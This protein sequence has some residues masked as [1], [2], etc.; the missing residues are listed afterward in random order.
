MQMT[1]TSIDSFQN[2]GI[3]FIGKKEVPEILYKRKL[4][5]FQS[6]YFNQ[7]LTGK[8]T[9]RTEFTVFRAMVKKVSTY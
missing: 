1:D 3:L 9:K 2:L 5:D 6:R 7:S 4:T 8:F